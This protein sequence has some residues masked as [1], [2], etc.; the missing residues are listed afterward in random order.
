[1]FV[2]SLI[3]YAHNF[4]LFYLRPSGLQHDAIEK[5]VGTGRLSIAFLSLES[6]VMSVKF[7]S[8]RKLLLS[9]GECDTGSYDRSSSGLAPQESLSPVPP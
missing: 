7:L 3:E 5:M 1:M 6:E 4:Y 2:L 9:C 8:C